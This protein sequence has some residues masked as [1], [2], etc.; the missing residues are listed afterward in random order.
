[1]IYLLLFMLLVV[2]IGIVTHKLNAKP[3]CDH[4]WHEHD[5]VVKCSKC[6]KCIPDRANRYSKAA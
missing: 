3:L 2:V 1:M 5:H 4:D 6:N